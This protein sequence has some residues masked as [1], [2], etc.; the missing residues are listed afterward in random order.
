MTSTRKEAYVSKLLPL[1]DKYNKCMI[2]GCDNVG[3]HHMQKIRASLR[4]DAEIL[5]GKNTMMRRAMRSQL[6]KNPALESLIAQ[7]K[8]NVALVFTEKDLKT[9][10]D[11]VLENKVAAPATTGSIAPCDVLIPKGPTGL[12]PSQTSFMQAL[13]I[14]TKINRGQVEIINDT[15]LLKVGEKVSSSQA[16]LL[17]KLKINP[18]SYGLVPISIYENG[19]VFSPSILDISDEDIQKKITFG[20]ERLAFLTLGLSYPSVIAVPVAVKTAYA[21]VAAL[22]V[23][24][25]LS[26]ARIE[27]IKEYLADPEAFAAAA[28]VV[29]VAAAAAPAA[30]A[31]AAAAEAEAPAAEAAPA[32][33]EEEEGG[34]GDLFG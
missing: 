9:V 5:C 13:N 23:E 28:P 3:S 22:A 26:F 20:L 15:P 30:A 18:F 17:Q 21:N 7:I 33:E 6:Q 29:E 19:S 12:D 8:G 25:D 34:F 32:E 31:P 4:K 27:K 14:A 10:R 1:L 24:T 2:V 16:T 11:I